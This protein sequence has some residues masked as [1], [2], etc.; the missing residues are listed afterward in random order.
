MSNLNNDDIA[1]WEDKNN[2]MTNLAE[3]SNLVTEL[4]EKEIA[5]YEWKEIYNIKSLEIEN[6]TDFKAI[7]GKNNDKIRKEHVKNELS[8]WY[9]T[10]KELKFSIDWIVR[11]ISFLKQLIYT[12]T[13]I[14][15][16]KE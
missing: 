3:W 12:K 13:I 2:I 15:E 5:L 9:E 14:M 7:Y 6:N 16:V 1:R 8:D 4:S 11:R 10:I